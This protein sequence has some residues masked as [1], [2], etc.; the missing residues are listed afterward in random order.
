MAANRGEI[1]VRVFRAA[2]E[3]GI[4]TVA[5]Y[6]KEDA[7]S[8][9]TKVA[10]QAFQL[11]SPKYTTPVSAYLAEDDLVDLAVREGVDAIHPGYG[12]LSENA[13]FAK[14]VLSAG[15]RWIGPR[16]DALASLGDKVEARK[17]AVAAGLPII[18]G[19][20]QPI[21][22]PEEA[23]AFCEQHGYPVIFKASFG[24]GG[25]GMRI[26][27]SPAD[28]EHAFQSAFREAEAAF[29]RGDLFVERFLP[30]P[31]HVEVQ[32]L[33]DKHGS[34]THLWDR[35]CSAQKRHQKVVEI[36]PAV[37]V[38]PSV[39]EKILRDAVTLAKHV[40]YE[41]AGTIEFLVDLDAT[42]GEYKHYFMEVNPRLQVEHT[43]TEQ[44]TGVDLVQAQI[45]VAEG[46]L[47]R[48][49]LGGDPAAIKPRGVSIQLRVTTSSAGGKISHLALPEGAGIRVDGGSYNYVG[50]DL[51]AASHFDPLLCKI[52]ATG[53]TLDHATKRAIH[54]CHV[55]HIEGEG[56]STNLP[57]LESILTH[58]HFATGGIDTNLLD[59]HPE[60]FSSTEGQRARVAKLLRFVAHK[61]VNR[62]YKYPQK[63]IREPYRPSPEA[64]RQTI[65]P[66]QKTLLPASF[67]TGW[68]D[69]LLKE[70]PESFAKRVREYSQNGGMLLMD[71]TMRDAHQSLLATRVR[72]RDL[73]TIAKAHAAA[74]R[75]AAFALE[76]WGGATFDVAL[77][78]LRE[79][80]WERLE[81]LREAIPDI[82]FSMLLRGSNAVGYTSYPDNVVREFCKEAHQ[83]GLDVFRVF[84]SLNYLPSLQFGCDAAASSG[85]FVEAAISYTGIRGKYSLDY[86]AKV[87]KG[88]VEAGAH[89]L[90]VKDMAGLL[91]PSTIK[92]LLACL[93]SVVPAWMPIHIH[94]HDSAGCG[95]A[96]ML[97]AAESGD[98]DIVDVALDSMSGLTSQPAAGPIVKALGDS[99]AAAGQGLKK[100]TFLQL[101]PLMEVSTYWE[102]LRAL[103][104]PFDV[105][106]EQR[107]TSADVYMNE[108][109]G[110][111]Y[112]NLLFQAS[113]LG[114]AEKWPQVKR[115]YTQANQLLGDIIKVT[116]SSHVC[117]S[118]AQF[119]VQNNLTPEQVVERA[120][121]LSFPQTVVEYFRG[122][123]GIP[124]GGFPAELQRKVLKGNTQVI[125]GRPGA[126]MPPM[127]LTQLGRDLELDSNVD[128]QHILS[129]ALYPREYAAFRDFRDAFG[130]DTT[131]LPT[132]VFFG[133]LQVGQSIN[134]ELSRG[135]HVEVKLLAIG[136]RNEHHVREVFL[137]VDGKPRS[138][139]VTEEI[140][141]DAAGAKGQ[142]KGG[143]AQKREKADKKD[144]FS[145][146][147]PMPGKV[148]KVMAREGTSVKKGEAL[149]VL[150]AMKME[151]V[152]AAPRD[153]LVKRILVGESDIV[154]G[155]DLVVQ[156]E[157]VKAV[158]GQSVA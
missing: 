75:P 149:C 25:R 22:S 145:V 77:Q 133:G 137:S 37:H 150:S 157:D 120:D 135:K 98:A 131:H 45:G 15:I 121:E 36:A 46:R 6:P 101:A 14:K 50:A 58:R 136:E 33:G 115:A 103:Y 73:V 92:S 3:L 55:T 53:S 113:A 76:M 109:P 88:C 132:D 20:S 140:A 83:R 40:G 143:K 108:I 35:D 30:H 24:G 26:V 47:L 147:A 65:V 8:M 69:V 38:H 1:A 91:T 59:S 84:D 111:Q 105:T 134:V 146:A 124:E 12:F 13:S 122:A 139:M 129:A 102:Q 10:R 93:R 28:L 7:G 67:V 106:R 80:P 31:R 74:F 11:A 104:A 116:P 110:G 87:A 141:D 86:Y 119:M 18:P 5:V 60:Q 89:G 34:V 156:L 32:I 70:G 63:M 64:V 56:V 82:P 127:D 155:G 9:H 39:R 85:G 107:A 100:D 90:C 27:R 112:S 19:T 138:I 126:S 62:D 125:D 81:R 29:G 152:V 43:V 153:G 2:H 51:S 61:S 21:Q 72:T 41:N 94:T 123:I 142:A 96:S 68:R 151:T 144:A 4:D 114:L 23:R 130:T 78:F 99:A 57:F 17:L 118:L 117:G 97:A 128:M 95:V 44:V 54:A 49:V 148:L 79:C 158:E 52:I 48:D 71:T 16:P 154:E 42:T 66:R